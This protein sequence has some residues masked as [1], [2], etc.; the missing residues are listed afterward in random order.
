MCMLTVHGV[1][2]IFLVIKYLYAIWELKKWHVGRYLYFIYTEL[3]SGNCT[4]FQG[5]VGIPGPDMMSFYA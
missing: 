1:V 3:L 2:S 4:Y 5:G